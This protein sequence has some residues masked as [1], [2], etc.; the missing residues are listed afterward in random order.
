MVFKWHLNNRPSGDRT[1]FDHLNTRLV[2]NY[3]DPHQNFIWALSGWL[4][5]FT[6]QFMFVILIHVSFFIQDLESVR[7]VPYQARLQAISAP[8][9][10]MLLPGRAWSALS[11]PL[12]HPTF[13]WARAQ[14]LPASSP[15]RVRAPSTMAP[16]LMVLPAWQAGFNEPRHLLQQTRH[17]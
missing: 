9:H 3:L 8:T 12:S 4:F 11:H 17:R 16:H 14:H 7:T 10:L 1:T 13:T 6:L 5:N 15:R 2:R